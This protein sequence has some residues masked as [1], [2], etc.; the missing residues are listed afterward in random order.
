MGWERIETISELKLMNID[1]ESFFKIIGGSLDV[2]NKKESDERKWIHYEAAYP[3]YIINESTDVTALPDK[4]ITYSVSTRDPAPI[5]KDKRQLRPIHAATWRHTESGETYT[6][7]LSRHLERIRFDIFAPT[8][9]E[10]E[11]TAIWFERF[12]ELRM[13]LLEFIG[14]ERILYAG[15]GLNMTTHR[16]GYHNRAIL[17]D[18]ITQ[19]HLWRK[20]QA[21]EEVLFG[22]G[23]KM[24]PDDQFEFPE[25]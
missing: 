24:P 7:L 14:L 10:A 4:I 1:L 18:I 11:H 6:L 2:E 3:D 9:T 20:N 16:T 12:M 25:V 22:F 23:L 5:G 21:I 15:R 13:E 19:D 17:Y 8:A